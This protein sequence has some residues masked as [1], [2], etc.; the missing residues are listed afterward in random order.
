MLLQKINNQKG[1]DLIELMIGIA[2]IAILACIAIPN[3]IAYRDRQKTNSEPIQIIT[4]QEEKEVK[5]TPH[6]SKQKEATEQKGDM[7]KL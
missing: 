7:N 3:F 6:S 1:F 5:E 2:I 4:Q